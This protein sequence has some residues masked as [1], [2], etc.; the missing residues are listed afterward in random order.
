MPKKMAIAEAPVMVA[1]RL[2]TSSRMDPGLRNL[3]IALFITVVGSLVIALIFSKERIGRMVRARGAEALHD[4]EEH[5]L[6]TVESV[7]MGKGSINI[8]RRAS[9][10]GPSTPKEGTVSNLTANA[11]GAVVKDSTIE[12]APAAA[13]AGSSL[14][15]LDPGAEAPPVDIKDIYIATPAVDET[16]D[17]DLAVGD[18][19]TTSLV[20]G[21]T[22]SAADDQ[23][24]FA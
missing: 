6:E 21:S 22:S 15:V 2:E 19:E 3:L 1:N 11:R 16:S 7:P 13:P 5:E 23:A 17:A 10:P 8:A 4:E 9:T 14:S 18:G 24:R 20:G 12:S